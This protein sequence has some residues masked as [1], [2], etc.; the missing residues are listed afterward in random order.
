MFFYITTPS[1]ALVYEVVGSFHAISGSNS[2][3]S[4]LVSL[5]DNF[6]HNIGNYVNEQSLR[7]GAPQ[8]GIQ[9]VH[10]QQQQR[11]DGRHVS[12]GC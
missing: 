5:L 4:T 7:S 3:P 1:A 6:G 8:V 2:L 9:H 11:H 10:L 12:L